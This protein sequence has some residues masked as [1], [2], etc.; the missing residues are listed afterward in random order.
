M[1]RHIVAVR[2]SNAA[3]AEEK[4]AIFA[5][6]AALKD[7]VEG[8]LDFQVRQNISPEEPVVH[9]LNDLFWFDFRDEA[10]RDAYLVD[11]AHVKAGAR[12]V[13]ASEGGVDGIT[14]LDFEV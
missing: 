10:S 11:P 14:V 2:F 8:A 6:L 1:I 3:S 4:A 7:I 9:G 13:A 5:E 12:L